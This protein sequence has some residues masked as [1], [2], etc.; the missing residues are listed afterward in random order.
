MQNNVGNRHI[1]FFN[2]KKN[3]FKNCVSAEK[4]NDD[5]QKKKKYEELFEFRI[6]LRL[7][8]LIDHCIHAFF[9]IWKKLYILQLLLRKTSS[10]KRKK[11][12]QS[13]I[14]FYYLPKNG[15]SLYIK[16]ST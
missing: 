8:V 9:Q 3:Q 13:S 12:I 16:V 15:S 7:G 4:K 6:F 1:W 14:T 10:W 11:K 5:F 2:Q